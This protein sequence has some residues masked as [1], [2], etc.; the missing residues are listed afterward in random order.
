MGAGAVA[1]RANTVSVGS[2][3]DERQVTNVAAGTANTDA[4]N[5]AQVNAGDT[6]TLSQARAYTDSQ[7]SALNDKFD[8]LRSGVNDRLHS[9][10]ERIDRMSAISGAYAGMAMNTAGLAGQNRVG[11]GIGAQGGQQAL[12]IGYQRAIGTRASVSLGGAFSGNE[13]SVMAGAGL[14]W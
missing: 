2:A 5:V 6:R 13:K 11:V 9:M 10:D 8:Q 3:G 12:A 1:D 4:A 7:A 14:S